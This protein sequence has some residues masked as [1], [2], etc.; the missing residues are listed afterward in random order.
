ME[1]ISRFDLCVSSNIVCYML[2]GC[3]KNVENVLNVVLRRE[4]DIVGLEF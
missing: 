4:I 3:Y 1:D 2:F